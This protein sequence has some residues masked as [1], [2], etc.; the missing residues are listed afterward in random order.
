MYLRQ[1]IAERLQHIRWSMK[2]SS[3]KYA[4]PNMT[5]VTAKRRKLV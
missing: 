5:Q 3:L 4:A 1:K 2:K